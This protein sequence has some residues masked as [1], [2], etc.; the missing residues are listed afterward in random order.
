[1]PDSDIA[2]L[3][4]AQKRRILARET[5]MMREMTRRWLEIERALEAEMLKVVTELGGETLVTEAMLLR[6]TRF[7]KLLYQARA[8]YGKFADYMDEKISEMQAEALK[9][10][11]DDAYK[12]LGVGLDGAGLAITFDKLPIGALE[13][14][15]GLT[16]D[17]STLKKLLMDSYGEAVNGI[18]AEMLTGLA[19]GLHPTDIA[20]LMANKFGVGLQ[21]ALTI[22]RTEQARAYRMASLEQYRNSGVV[23]QYKR[24]AKKDDTT[25]LGCLFSDG[26]IYETEDEFSEH[27]N[28][29]CSIIP[30]VRGVPEPTWET[31]KEWFENLSE[32]RQRSILGEA[33]F[34]LWQSG[35]SLDEMTQLVSDP[36]WGGKVVP[37]PI[38]EL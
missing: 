10:G 9:D 34:D 18:I 2:R 7:Q 38:S 24:M 26:E 22:A 20:E 23:T 27:P 21:R 3:V 35:T 31:G 36:T 25:C 12:V 14:M 8:E 11:I 33:R 16:A 17:G 30:V 28:G 4:E 6:N 37:T 29:R 19:K 1:M 32:D 5:E 13:T 15:I